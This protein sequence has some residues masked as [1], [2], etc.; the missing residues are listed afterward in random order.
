MV[1]D[2]WDGWLEK[3]HR[4]AVT[5]GEAW[6]PEGQFHAQAA[7]EHSPVIHQTSTFAFHTVKE[8][9]QRFVGS[10]FGKEK[11]FARVYTRLGNPTTEHLEKVL[12]HL[13][14]QHLIDAALEANE[15]KPSIGVLV[16]ASGMGAISVALMG[17]VRSGDAV[18][19]GTVY[20]CTDSLLRKLEEQFGVEVLWTDLSDLAA[21]EKALD[22]HPRVAALYAETPANP[23]LDLADIRALADLSEP[24]RIPLVV[25]NTFATPFLQQPFRMGADVVLHSLTKY[26]NGHSS[27]IL[28][29]CLGPWSFISDHAFPWYKDL[30]VTPS[31]FESWQNSLHVKTLGYRVREASATAMRLAEWLE[32]RPEVAH[33]YYPGLASHPQHQLAERQMRMPGA[34]IAFDLAGGY[35]PSVKLMNVMARRNTPME[36]AVSLGA[37]TTYIQ[38]PASMTHAG[39]PPEERARR[40]ITDGLIRV[41]VGLEGYDYLR[42]GLEQGF[43][44]VA[45]G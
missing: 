33:V 15:R 12:F 43:R 4:Y 23:T 35:D 5:P 39:M 30:G 31:P 36:L 3:K 8:G 25:D 28:G 44:E 37:T 27:G 16:T 42:G 1:H 2:W 40:G 17:L 41:S 21:V 29:A 32:G 14:C 20:G 34:M 24:R 19:A 18:V 22:S 9:A 45:G 26:V 11:P 13:E 10:T 6:G 7:A 38:H